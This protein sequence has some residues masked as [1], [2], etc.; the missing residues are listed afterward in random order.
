MDYTTYQ[1]PHAHTHNAY[2]PTHNGQSGPPVT[3]PTQQNQVSPIM[4]QQNHA[5]GQQPGAAHQV[6]PMYSQGYPVQGMHYGMGAN[7]MSPTQAAAMA[8]AAASG[9]YN[10][11]PETM[12][13]LAQD[14]RQSPRMGQSV[15]SE[16][17][18]T[19]RSPSQSHMNVNTTMAGQM[20]MPAPQAIPQQMVARRMSQA[21]QPPQPV[22]QQQRRSSVAPQM[23]QQVVQQH[24]SPEAV[25]TTEESPLYVNAKQFHRILKRR[26]ARQKL[27]E[28]LRLTSKGRKPYLHESRHNHA[29]RRPRGPGGRFLTAEEV[30]ALDAEAAKN[31]GGG[32]EMPQPTNGTKRKSGDSQSSPSKKSRTQSNARSM[33]S[34]EDGTEEG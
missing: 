30:A 34:E 11:M 12:Q 3:S 26:L 10:Y 5:Y 14:P 1:Q 23:V 8:T 18:Q 32:V 24:S 29:M 9:N 2:A 28:Q 15:K 31:G 20:V 17:R 7:Q 21:V 4:S 6:M 27:E 19:P 13:P 22:M 33:T 25:G 16:Q